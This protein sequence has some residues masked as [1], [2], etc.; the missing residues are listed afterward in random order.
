MVTVRPHALTHPARTARTHGRSG[1]EPSALPLR[2]SLYNTRALCSPMPWAA[3]VFS[4]H[5]PHPSASQRRDR[6]LPPSTC[7]RTPLHRHRIR[8]ATCGRHD[9]T[10]ERPPGPTTTSPA[11]LLPRKR[12]LGNA[13]CLPGGHCLI[14]ACA[15]SSY[16][17]MCIQPR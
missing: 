15:L 6:R 14:T 1:Y 17:A 5:V 2:E 16:R 9:T 7:P 8:P 3:F 13:G 4:Q 10:V 12:P 11:D